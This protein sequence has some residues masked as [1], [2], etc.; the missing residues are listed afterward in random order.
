[1]SGTLTDALRVEI[2]GKDFFPL[3]FSR[4]GYSGK[5]SGEEVMY[6]SPVGLRSAFP[7]YFGEKSLPSSYSKG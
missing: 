3:Q 7:V 2:S 5:V 6:L 4:S 1:M